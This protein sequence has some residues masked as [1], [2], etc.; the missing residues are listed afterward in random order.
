MPFA[1]K[2]RWGKTSYLLLTVA[3]CAFAASLGSAAYAEDDTDV[4]E[5]E[6]MIVTVERREQNIQDVAATVQA[7]SPDELQR[8]GVNDEFRNLQFVVPG[9]QITN[10][11]GRTEVFLRGIGSFDAE[12]SSDPSVA[13]FFN[14]VY[15]GRPRG[16][17]LLFFDS[18]RVEVNKGPQGTIRGRNSQG[19]T[20]N[21]ISAA[22]DF[23]EFGGYVQGGFGNFS[24]NEFEA[25]INLPITDTLAVRGSMFFRENDGL[26]TN[27]FVEGDDEAFD[28][29][30]RRDDIAGR[31]SVLWEPN[32][33]L[34]WS[35]LWQRSSLDGGGDPGFFHG[36]SLAA[37]FDINDLE[38]PFNQ[39]FRS[40]G[41]FDQ[42]VSVYL[43][44][45]TYDF[46]KFSIEYNGSFSSTVALNGNSSRVQGVGSVFP[47]SEADAAIILDTE[48]NGI[49]N[50]TQ[51]DTFFQGEDSEALIQELRFFGEALDNKLTWTAGAFF[52]RENFDGVS[53]DVGNGF[54]SQ[55]LANQEG[56]DPNTP[57]GPNPV[58][59]FQ[60][61]LGGEFRNDDAIVRSIAGYADFTYEFTDR[62]RFK[63]G[64]R[65]TNDQKTQT[66]FNAAYQVDINEDLFLS[67]DGIAAPGDQTFVGDGFTITGP[68]QRASLVPMPGQETAFLLGAF[69]AFG[70]GDTFDDVLFA[71]VGTPACL[72]T[73]TSTLDDPT[74]A[75]VEL[76][77]LVEEDFN[78]VD[79]R[80]GVEFDMTEDS[81]V[82]FTASTGTRSGGINAPV[83]LATG[84]LAPSTFDSEELI[85]YELGSKNTFS[86][87][88][89]PVTVNAAAFFYSFD[90]QIIQNLVSVANPTPVNPDGTT[91]RVVIDNVGG[92][93]AFGI[94]LEAAAHLPFG[95]QAGFNVLYLDAEYRDAALFDPRDN[96]P[97]I[98]ISGNDL[99]NTSRWNINARLYQ[100]IAIDRGYLR[101]FDWTVN[102]LYRSSYF[103]S[104]FNNDDLD[105]R[106]AGLPGIN[107]FIS[108]TN[109][110]IVQGS[111][112]FRSDV[113]GFVVLNA[114]IGFN[115]GE[116]GRFRID[117]FV[118]N[119]T[120]QAFSGRGFINSAV[121]IRFLNQ[122]RQFGG[123][124]RVRF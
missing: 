15:I 76:N 16:I 121:N 65:F 36:R 66:N 113:P 31:I 46:E 112:F 47:G 43:T 28:G 115:F 99:Q 17:G 63:G 32:D 12:F 68:G 38:D 18:Q 62:L 37:G 85:L 117:G 94:E 58:S 75:I 74:T 87:N 11:E 55:F 7:F 20:I 8:L 30:G 10:N 122:P 25:A 27:E 29:P 61:G 107:S 26:Y 19:G 104:P 70:V 45:L 109:Q 79:W 96:T 13:T 93:R 40:P 22:P 98:D 39:Y 59:C 72:T 84:E 102:L 123:R 9:L 118:N 71:C 69:E 48:N 5:M 23:E 83:I 54:C 108:F 42:D 51:Q 67:I 88:N 3:S 124:L 100:E 34:S 86:V 50:I 21:I 111:E 49:F 60:N 110:D 97:D 24:M 89:Y 1:C 78:F 119:A 4:P 90:D 116:D 105:G 52:Y 106:L 73:I 53:F 2:P 44:T 41:D 81:L 95:F 114:V 64:V 82:Y 77:T 101:S 56:F 33:R 6:E 14:N 80:A 120:N 92:A 103:L 57:L 35:F 91:E